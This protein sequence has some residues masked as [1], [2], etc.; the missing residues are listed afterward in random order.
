MIK[1][2]VSVYL[3]GEPIHLSTAN[4]Y[5]CRPQALSSLN[6]SVSQKVKVISK[7]GF[8]VCNQRKKYI[9]IILFYF[10]TNF[11]AQLC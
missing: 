9:K 1:L 3:P 4:L 5:T 10:G 6:V 8:Q 7:N 2:F 11:I